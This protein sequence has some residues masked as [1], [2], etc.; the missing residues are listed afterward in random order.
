LTEERS[1]S[2]Q[3]HLL[4]LRKRLF[5]SSIAIVITT[6]I[7]FAFHQQIL[8]LLMAPAGGFDTIPVGKPIYTEITEFIST[9]M[10]ASLMAGVFV[11]FPFV[12]FQLALFVSP[13]LTKSERRYLF[14]LLPVAIIVFLIGAAFGYKVL[15]PPMINFLLNFGTEVATPQ[16]RIGR[17]VSTVLSL[18]IWLGVLFETPVVLFFLAKIGLVTPM[19]LLKNWRYALVVAFILGAIITPSIDPVN[20]AIVAA[21]I[22]GLYIAGIGM[23]W[24]GTKCRS[25]NRS[26][27]LE[28]AKSEEPEEKEEA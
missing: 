25:K 17:Y 11:S 6:G 22:L 9:A 2:I 16:I 19:F 20:Q 23:A 18:L 27:E 13:G 5:Y 14:A 8:T 3:D 15:I 26:K 4:E 24:V 21:P 7:A 1:S 28:E 10:K 12:F